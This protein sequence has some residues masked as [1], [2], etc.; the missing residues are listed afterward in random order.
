MEST[1]QEKTKMPTQQEI[2]KGIYTA[3]KKEI[4]YIDTSKAIIKLLSEKYCIAKSFELLQEDLQENK[5]WKIKK[6]MSELQKNDYVTAV[7]IDCEKAN[8]QKDS[9][10]LTNRGTRLA[11]YLFN[12]EKTKSSTSARKAQSCCRNRNITETM[13]RGT[14][15]PNV[16]YFNSEYLGTCLSEEERAPLRGLYCTG[17]LLTP[18]TNYLLYSLSDR[19]VA[20]YETREKNSLRKIEA[21]KGTEIKKDRENYLEGFDRIIFVENEKAVKNMFETVPFNKWCKKN[22][23]SYARNYETGLFYRD[24]TIMRGQAFVIERS[25]NQKSLIKPFYNTPQTTMRMSEDAVK[26]YVEIKRGELG[27]KAKAK[28]YQLSTVETDKYIVVNLIVQELHKMTLVE[29]IIE[30]RNEKRKVLVFTTKKQA[31]FIE[32]CYGEGKIRIATIEEE[33]LEKYLEEKRKQE[34]K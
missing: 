15:Q 14:L 33:M 26:Q 21:L 13:L 24:E 16:Q 6:A 2:N 34:M 29:N 5:L 11:K 32:R 3:F 28:K 23:K 25:I 4:K 22:G 10:K 27:E 12:L 18:E 31:N 20:V 1:I 9:W 30:D 7:A 8:N 19:N 17:Y